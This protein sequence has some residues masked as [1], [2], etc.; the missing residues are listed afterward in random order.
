MNKNVPLI[1]SSKLE[2]VHRIQLELLKTNP[3]I[4]YSVTIYRRIDN[5][6]INWLSKHG[7]IKTKVNPSRK[8]M[9]TTSING[10]TY[11]SDN[12]HSVK[13]LIEEYIMGLKP[14]LTELD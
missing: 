1:F 6:Q 10:K 2:F 3:Y 9:F 12:I 5:F 8:L 11:F 13:K 7:L 4:Y 14:Q